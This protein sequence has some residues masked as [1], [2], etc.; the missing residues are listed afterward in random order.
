MSDMAALERRYR[1]MLGWFPADHRRVYGEEMIGVLLASAPTDQ[2]RP[3]KADALDLIGSGM[4]AR[5]RRLQAGDSNPAWRDA[6]AAF[7]VIAPVLVFT[8]LA[9]T[10]VTLLAAE[11]AFPP[12]PP[13]RNDTFI[14][15]LLA[16]AVALAAVVFGPVLA[17]RRHAGAATTIGV[18]GGALA[19]AAA[20]WAFVTFGPVGWLV[21]YFAFIVAIELVAIVASPGPGRGWQ[22]LGRKGLVILAAVALALA[23]GG[24]L[25][26]LWLY[27]RSRIAGDLGNAANSVAEIAPVVGMVLIALILRWPI[28]G[29]LLALFAIPA[30][31]FAGFDAARYVFPVIQSPGYVIFQATYLPAAAIAAAVLIAAWRSG[32]RDRSQTP[33]APA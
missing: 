26:V 22:L 28:G 8:Q 3:S 30:Y 9:V 4:R 24:V 2:D 32:R 7:S 1:R 10:Y 19:V 21:A 31:P 23:V 12:V 13:Q 15:M 14:A 5:F 25:D 17:R 11:G 18:I 16:S 20:I 6:L 29:R 27:L 33:G